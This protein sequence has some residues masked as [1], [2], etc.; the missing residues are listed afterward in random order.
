MKKTL[1]AIIVCIAP[2][3]YG[4]IG[5][6]TS[7]NAPAASGAYDPHPLPAGMEAPPPIEQ[8]PKDAFLRDPKLTAKLQKLLPKGP[9]IQDACNG[10]KNLGDCVAAIHASQNLEIPF[11]DLKKKVTGKDAEKLDKAIHELKPD[12]NASSEKKKA[13][14]QAEKDIPVSN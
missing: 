2:F 1:L 8:S 5:G 3:C 6:A 13:W 14:K 12:V 11:D 9:M 10:F 7:S 4:Q